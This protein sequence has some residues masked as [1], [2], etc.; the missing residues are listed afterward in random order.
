MNIRRKLKSAS[1]FTLAET[2]LA[3]LIM[4]LVATIMANGI[5][6]AQSAYE[7]VV[8]SANAQ[9]LLSTT[10]TTLRDELGTAWD[11]VLDDDK[12][13]IS[14]YSADTG[15]RTR[16]HIASDGKIWRQEFVSMDGLNISLDKSVGKDSELISQATATNS[17][18]ISCG[19]SIDYDDTTGVVTFKNL[20]VKSKSNTLASLDTLRI[21]VFSGKT[22]TA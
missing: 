11:V 2:M 15:A 18:T 12:K 20:V 1:G 5:P 3:V 22:K 16:I 14:F 13:G 6:V 17:L 19:D 21:S 4:L 10:I 7:K 8:L 9:S